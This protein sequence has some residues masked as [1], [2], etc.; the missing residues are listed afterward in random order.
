MYFAHVH[1][2]FNRKILLPWGVQ[3][4]LNNNHLWSEVIF[5]ILLY[6]Y[7]VVFRLNENLC[8]WFQ[9]FANDY[10]FIIKYYVHRGIHISIYKCE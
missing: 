3:I 2:M 9:R 1:Y 6:E 10:N 5:E 4:I 8:E 7:I